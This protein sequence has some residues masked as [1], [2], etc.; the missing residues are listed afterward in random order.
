[1]IQ[2]LLEAGADV[3]RLNERG[4]T[5]LDWA[6]SNGKHQAVKALRAAGGVT[7]HELI[8]PERVA[9]L[10]LQLGD[11]SY[12]VREVADA[13]L[14]AIAPQ[15]VKMLREALQKTHDLE[16]EIRLRRILESLPPDPSG[17]R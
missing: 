9:S 5:A 12:K 4:D 11:D 6:F 14:R 1:M 10:I 7:G 2:T 15:V 3:N 13:A 16:R 8:G 17:S